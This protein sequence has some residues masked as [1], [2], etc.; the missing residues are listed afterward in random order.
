MA[1]RL[2][3][4]L[5]FHLGLSRR[6]ADNFIADGKVTIN[7]AVATL[8][9]RCKPEDVVELNGK[10]VTKRDNYTY[11]VLHKPTDYVSSR[12]H[13]GDSPTVYDLLP[14]EY[15]NLKP[16]GRLDRDTSGILLF[17]DD[18]EFA[19][20]MTHP[21]FVKV[22]VYEAELDLP[23]EPLHQQM[24]SDHGVRLEDGVS[25]LGLERFDDDRKHWRITMHEGRNRQIRRTFSSLGYAVVKLHR[26]SFGSYQLNDLPEGKFQLIKTG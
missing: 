10:P 9:D 17:T 1:E 18:G 19:H 12:R 21:S 6:E 3:K 26:T 13:Q 15:H 8:G 22:K 11:M 23:L 7:G 24:I 25:K 20:Q 5:A 14:K 2:N 16:V 4:Y